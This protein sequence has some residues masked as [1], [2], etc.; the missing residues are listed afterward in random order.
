VEIF[1][2]VNSAAEKIHKFTRRV[3]GL[4]GNVVRAIKQRAKMIFILL[5]CALGVWGCSACYMSINRREG[6][7]DERRA[8]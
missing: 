3:F 8:E 2:K 7:E 1:L 5:V 6:V 4:G